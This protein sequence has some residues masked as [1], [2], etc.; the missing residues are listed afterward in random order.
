MKRLKSEASMQSSIYSVYF[1]LF[2]KQLFLIIFQVM[3]DIY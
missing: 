3:E 1:E 2:V